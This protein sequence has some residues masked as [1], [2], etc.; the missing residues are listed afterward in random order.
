MNGN[1]YRE[2]QTVGRSQMRFCAEPLLV[3]KQKNV[4]FSKLNFG[5]TLPYPIKKLQRRKKL[6]G[7]RE[8][9]KVM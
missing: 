1:F 5:Q 9:C 7:L 8:F 2:I 3:V 4:A 6:A